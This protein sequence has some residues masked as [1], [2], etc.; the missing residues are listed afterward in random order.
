MRSCVLAKKNRLGENHQQNAKR[1][2]EKQSGLATFSSGHG[3]VWIHLE[4]RRGAS[5]AAN[6]INGRITQTHQAPSS[7]IQRSTKH[8][9]PS[10]A[11]ERWFC[12]LVLEVS[13]VLG[14]WS[15]VLQSPAFHRK[16]P[17]IPQA[18]SKPFMVPVAEAKR[19]VSKPM[20]W[21]METKR[22]GS[23]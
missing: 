14:C 12:R 10:K 23:G 17:E 3:L 15:L 18:I 20:R 7:N 11:S 5:D 4:S 6:F 1:W 2:R 9:I 22:L 19:S 13:L 16:C 8:Q 21:S